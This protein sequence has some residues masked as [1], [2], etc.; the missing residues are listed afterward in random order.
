MPGFRQD[1]FFEFDFDPR[2]AKPAAGGP[3]EIRGEAFQE[4]AGGAAGFDLEDLTEGVIVDGF[5]EV[6][7]IGGLGKG[8]DGK[9]GGAE[10]GLGFTP[11]GI[12]D[13]EMAG[14][15]QINKRERGSHGLVQVKV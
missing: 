1:E 9:N 14:Q 4:F 13:A 12:G 10:D 6:V 7:P 15:L 11:F 8:R 5:A 3:G 2:K